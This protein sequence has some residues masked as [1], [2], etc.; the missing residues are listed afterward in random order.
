MELQSTS[1][2]YFIYDN[3]QKTNEI[4]IEHQNIK[5]KAIWIQHFSNKKILSVVTKN[6]TRRLG[7]VR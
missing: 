4:K 6:Q 5:L 3:E 1:L 2:K 7:N